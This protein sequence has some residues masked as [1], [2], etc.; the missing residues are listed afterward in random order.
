MAI[1]MI[2]I[3]VGISIG[4]HIEATV[5]FFFF[6]LLLLVLRIRVVLR[7]LLLRNLP[8]FVFSLSFIPRTFCGLLSTRAPPSRVCDELRLTPFAL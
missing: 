2:I 5:L 7:F 1:I 8:S 4:I 3:V 6:L